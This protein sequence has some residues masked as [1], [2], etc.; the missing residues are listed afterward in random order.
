MIPF[1]AYTAAD[2]QCFSMAQ[3]TP[4]MPIPVG[5]LDPH[6]MH[7]S[8][9]HASQQLKPHLDRFRRMWPADRHTDGSRYSV[10]SNRP[11]L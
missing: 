3:T 9:G 7:G 11:H 6:L 8:F 1:A 5:N 10:Y 2:S 4:K